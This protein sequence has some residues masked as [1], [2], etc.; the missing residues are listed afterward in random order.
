MQK[1][2]TFQVFNASAGSGKTYTLVKEYLKILLGSADPDRFRTILAVTFTNKAAG[3]MKER[4]ISNLRA[5]SRSDFHDPS[6]NLQHQIQAELELDP[7]TLH[8]RSKKVLFQILYNYS[9]FNITTIDSFTHRLIRNFA[10]DLGLSL[11]FDVEM[12][13]RSLLNEAVDLLI[14]KIGEDKELTEVL[15]AYS[16]QK[17]NEDRSWDV[18]NDLKEMAQLLLNE[19][20]LIHV[21]HLQKKSLTDFIELKNKLQQSIRN[22]KN[23]LQDIG[24]ESLTLLS[25]ANLV[26]EN[27][28]RKTFPNFLKDL[29]NFEDKFDYAK[30]SETIDKAIATHNFYTKSA[31]DN[32]KQSIESVL[33]ELIGL[34]DKSKKLYQK[35]KRYELLL[36]NTIPLAV[37]SKINECL[38][39]LKARKNVHLNAEFNALI[40]AHLKEQPAAF[41][42]ERLGETYRHYFIDEM[43]DTSALQWQNLV[44]LISN[45]LSQE[46][47]SLL[48][49]GDAKQSI[50][51]W[52]GGEAEQFMALATDYNPFVV[53]KTTSQLGTN[54]RSYSIINEFNN[55]FFKQVSTYFHDPLYGQMYYKENQQESTDKKGGYVQLS[56]I[57]QGFR[58]EEKDLIYAKQVLDIVVDLKDQYELQEICVLTRTRKQGIAIADFLIDN[59]VDIVSSETLLLKHSEII[60]FIINTL[61]YLQ[62]PANKQAQLEMVYFLYDWTQ[63]NEDKHQFLSG[64]MKDDRDVFFKHLQS[65]HFSFEFSVY[66]SLPLY[67][68][69]EYIVRTFTLHR[70][71]DSYLLF[72]LDEVSQYSRRN[73]GGTSGFLDYWHEKKDGL[74]LV[75]PQEKNAVRIMTIHKSKGLEF[76]V[77]IFPHD[78]NVYFENLA[79]IWYPMVGENDL[80]DFEHL[81]IS[82]KNS[83]TV[84][85]STGETGTALLEAH[86]DKLELDAINLLYV[87]L[88]RSIEQLYV[89]TENR[90]LT[91]EPSW[92]SHYFLA[93]LKES[94][95]YQEDKKL[96]EFGSKK[97]YSKKNLSLSAT[98]GL[99]ELISSSWHQRNIATQAQL[100][101]KTELGDAI[102]YGNLV[103]QIL[104]RIKFSSDIEEAL[105]LAK[106]EHDLNPSILSDLKMT[107]DKLISH[108]VLAPY[109][110]PGLRVFNERE[111]LTQS[112]QIAIPDRVVVDAQSQATI[113]D[114][115]TGVVDN[116]H[117]NQLK[118]YENAV[119]DL[120]FSVQKKMLVY[121]DR[122]I[123]VVEV[124]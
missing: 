99:N 10:F 69:I 103:H 4:V 116:I 34:F 8:E 1:T 39:E 15:V 55:A 118:I 117:R 9:A 88:T 3:E 89:L 119:Q 59:G 42:Y 23:K 46:D 87:A 64:L 112:Q 61:T 24:A 41:I 107:L 104:G 54:Y 75:V 26:P 5:F 53:D 77:V 95:Y 25:E 80:G 83:L 14:A 20:D 109:F 57:D 106:Q 100:I 33:P 2:T 45:A 49:V 74:S 32:I 48:L 82:N 60:Q 27:F 36:K 113:I 102:Q 115:K 122:D 101:W 51:R 114:Y 78:L 108:P 13:T 110:K 123:K 62:Q 91:E 30:R 18:A 29:K 19:N 52:R 35:K 67:E 40:S 68:R 21:Q 31:S 84:L 124:D 44:P 70:V 86:K 90:S 121:I 37:L 65:Y 43:Q 16:L 98:L 85:G 79:K 72:F 22:A 28:T 47:S 11:N 12:D 76:P 96:Y 92:Y 93:Y 81:L 94:G 66:S 58:S 71:P 63:I 38:N 111:I 56:F 50:Y 6:S 120:G 7:R 105:D 97:R 17:T 73:A